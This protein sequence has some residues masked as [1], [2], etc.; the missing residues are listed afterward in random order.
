MLGGARDI[1]TAV[2]KVR[3][4]GLLVLLVLAFAAPVWS[5]GQPACT[6]D[7]SPEKGRPCSYACGCCPCCQLPAAMA[8]Q[9]EIHLVLAAGF[10]CLQP[11]PSLPSPEPR[12]VLHVP[13]SA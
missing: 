13:K 1:K 3:A 6:D 7:C 2:V 4:L 9:P 10:A 8:A 12:A 5:L 11:P